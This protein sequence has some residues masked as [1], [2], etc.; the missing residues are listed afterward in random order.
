MV[1]VGGMVETVG[2]VDRDHT[3]VPVGLV[4]HLVLVLAV[5]AAV[6]AAAAQGTVL[7]ALA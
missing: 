1:A 2:M 4:D 6:V 7:G 5:V 3:A